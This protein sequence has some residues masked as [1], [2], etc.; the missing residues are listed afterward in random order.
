MQRMTAGEYFAKPPNSYE[1]KSDLDPQKTW[2]A[3]HTV[4]TATQTTQ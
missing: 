3:P 2:L 4:Y 1:R